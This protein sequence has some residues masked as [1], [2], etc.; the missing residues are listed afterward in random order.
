MRSENMRVRAKHPTKPNVNNVAR[1]QGRRGSGRDLS[2]GS[3]PDGPKS[4]AACD[5]VMEEGS[6]AS[7]TTA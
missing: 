2:S 3:V 5:A 4:G 7:R 6:M 1:R